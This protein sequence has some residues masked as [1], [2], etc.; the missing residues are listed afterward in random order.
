M[1]TNTLHISAV[2]IDEP[3][4]VYERLLRS[5]R[6]MRAFVG[7]DTILAAFLVILPLYTIFLGIITPSDE[8]KVSWLVIIIALLAFV[9]LS[10]IVLYLLF[11]VL[12]AVASGNLLI[13]IC[14]IAYCSI[15][16]LFIFPN[17]LY[18][19]YKLANI[20]LLTVPGEDDSYCFNILFVIT[21]IQASFVMYVLLI[22]LIKTI[23]MRHSPFF[24]LLHDHKFDQRF[25]PGLANILRNFW[26][27]MGIST[28]PL[29]R[30]TPKLVTFASIGA[31]F[32]EGS[33]VSWYMEQSGKL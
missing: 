18:H 1:K 4:K 8:I 17:L 25:W 2:A 33:A 10:F 12:R 29:P 28:L 20:L 26:I 3:A 32:L 31:F 7:A 22:G 15:G 11:Y 27:I 21:N 9:S 19:V 14:Y 24:Q 13:T 5:L 30:E 23:K 6:L 16:L